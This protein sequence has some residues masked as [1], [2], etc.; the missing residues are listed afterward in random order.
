MTWE[1]IHGL[2]QKILQKMLIYRASKNFITLQIM[3]PIFGNFPKILKGAIHKAPNLPCFP[4]SCLV[5]PILA[6][7]LPAGNPPFLP[8]CQNLA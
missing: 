7:D 4:L 2:K 8:F 3:Q 5:H 6:L 1:D